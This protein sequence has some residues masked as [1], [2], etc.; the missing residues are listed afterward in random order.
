MTKC[1]NMQLVIWFA[2]GADEADDEGAEFVFGRVGHP[3]RVSMVVDPFKSLH[4]GA[5]F[6]YQ[7]A[8]RGRHYGNHGEIKLVAFIGGGE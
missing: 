7:C 1:R 4:A 3:C 8:G 6:V 2:D 5:D